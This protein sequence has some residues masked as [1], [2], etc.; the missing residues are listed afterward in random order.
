MRGSR[1][2]RV[3]PPD[4]GPASIWVRF[5][6]RPAGDPGASG[7]CR[8]H[9]DGPHLLAAA[10]VAVRRSADLASPTPASPGWQR[11]S[12]AIPRWQPD[13]RP[14]SK[15][16]EAELDTGTDLSALCPDGFTTGWTPPC[17]RSPRQPSRPA[18]GWAP[19]SCCARSVKAAW[20]R[21][22]WRAAPTACTT[23][24]QPSLLRTGLTAE[25]LQ[26]ASPANVRVLARLDH[27]AVARLLDAGIDADQAYLV[28]EYGRRGAHRPRARALHH[29]GQPRAAAA[30]HCRGG[31]PRART[32]HRAP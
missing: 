9:A 6:L 5:V 14:C 19:G 18:R 8:H 12:S 3:G 25:G 28:L 30:S 22:G 20:A 15:K 31:G 21:C 32:A 11:C 27:P 1:G 7:Y 10:V 13:W 16:P 2:G 24:R 17:S 26:G 23:R 4:G 29:A